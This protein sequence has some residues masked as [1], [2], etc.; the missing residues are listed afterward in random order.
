MSR[1]AV[2]S[3]PTA[4]APETTVTAE[5]RSII[6]RLGDAPAWLLS[7]IVHLVILLVF[8]S[9]VSH[10]LIEPEPEIISAIEEPE[11][12]QY[13]FETATVL[14]EIG[15][16]SNMNV[17]SPSKAAATAVGNEPQEQFERRLDQEFVVSTVP[18][19]DRIV[20]PNELD[21]T[22]AFDVTGTTEHTG[23][24]DGAI[25]R[26]TN[27]IAASLR[28][29]ETTIVWLFDASLSLRD[30]REK[31]ADRFETIYAQLE[32]LGVLGEERLL[33]IAATYADKWNLLT[34][35]PTEDIASVAQKIREIPNPDTALE[36]VLTAVRDV[37]DRF[38]TQRT[39]ERRR[40]MVVIVTDERGDDFANLDVVIKRL[41]NYG[42]KVYCVGNA[43]PLGEVKEYVNW[44][45]D[46]GFVE[47]LSVDRGPEA[48]FP[49]LLSLP[50][51]GR[52][53]PKT[54]SSGY[55]PYGLTRLTAETGGLYLL[56]EETA[57]RFE[58]AIM[59][60]YAPDYRPMRVVEGEIKKNA[61]KQALVQ[62]AALSQQTDRR[63]AIPMP[64]R[65][66]P[67]ENDTVLRQAITEA[68][69]PMAIVDYQLL[70]LATLLENGLRDREKLDSQRWRATFDL[71]IGRVAAL[72]ARA[73]GY[74]TVLA[75]MKVSPKVFEKANSNQWVLKPSDAIGGGPA[76]K[77]LA[78][79]AREHLARVVD[80]H[81]GTP[82][83]DLA[84]I[85]LST[86]MGWEWV[87]QNDLVARF[88]PRAAD[89]QVARLLL[90]EEEER[91]Q[92]QKP[93]PPKR[94]ERPKL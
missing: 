41:K 43:A 84:A 16:D 72:R 79:T 90:A 80:E 12:D 27:E 92:M 22:S 34:E 51:W 36:N 83:A 78:E 10:S 45:Y 81:P 6:S 66:F 39:R 50:F 56:A 24:V 70:E 21:L 54:L 91:R 19:Q 53:A 1:S 35:E 25:D 55:G 2:L 59:R 60:N 15:N 74:N 47:A 11:L 94:R 88:G 23:G 18:A 76:V 4:T 67:A 86:P 52:G 77:K 13:K 7:A 14:D 69:K 33:T 62:A 8:A 49:E 40:M 26:L 63:E 58:P 30:R 57:K 71:A 37:T 32:E 68:Q 20:Q 48:A 3:P 93:E 38:L 85:E 46:D 29:K 65:V 82:W 61:A 75:E 17:V 9:I 42:I 31:I 44:T 5:P 89:P 73:Y 87:E 64:R 28:E